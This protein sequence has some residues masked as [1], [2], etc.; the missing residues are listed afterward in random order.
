[1]G[2]EVQTVEHS[3]RPGIAAAAAAAVCCK[4]IDLCQRL[5]RLR[6]DAACVKPQC[7]TKARHGFC[8]CR[9]CCAR[10]LHNSS[11]GALRGLLQPLSLLSV[12]FRSSRRVCCCC[13]LCCCCC[14]RRSCCCGCD[15]QGRVCCGCW[16]RAGVEVAQQHK[17]AAIAPAV[18]LHTHTDMQHMHVYTCQQ[19]CH[20][21]Q[22]GRKCS[23]LNRCATCMR[24]MPCLCL[25]PHQTCAAGR[26]GTHLQERKYCGL[27]FAAA[28]HMHLC[29]S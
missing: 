16:W 6:L 28:Q 14:C 25:W 1:M 4:R 22:R 18:C 2:V 26:K 20:Q 12:D 8:C 23:R 29:V 27:E 19:Q 24:S 17:L 5:L 13:H 9:R 15:S 10:H 3:W 21:R 11:R 7:R